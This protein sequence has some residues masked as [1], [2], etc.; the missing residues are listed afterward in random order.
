M[1]VRTC[2][3]LFVAIT[4]L[5]HNDLAPRVGRDVP[6]ASVGRLMHDD[7]DGGVTFFHHGREFYCRLFALFAQEV[8]ITITHRP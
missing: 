6:L 2:V 1:C 7:V 3:M 5:L 4:D 8:I